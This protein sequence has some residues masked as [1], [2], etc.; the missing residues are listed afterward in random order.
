IRGY[1]GGW[2]FDFKN[3]NYYFELNLFIDSHYIEKD[4][5]PLMEF[6]CEQ[7][8]EKNKKNNGSTSILLSNSHLSEINLHDQS[9]TIA[10]ILGE[11]MSHK[12]SP[13][14]LNLSKYL[15]NW[16]FYLVHRDLYCLT[17]FL[18]M[19]QKSIRGKMSYKLRKSSN[20]NS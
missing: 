2:E 3:H 4:L 14:K 5:Q 18:P 1:L 9:N 12:T 10:H 11:F 17:Y 13:K 8:N 16:C 6:L 20:T 19:S 15:R 7:I